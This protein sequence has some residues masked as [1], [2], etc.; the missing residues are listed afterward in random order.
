LSYSTTVIKAGNV[1]I[2]FDARKELAAAPFKQQV[3]PGT[4]ERPGGLS[5]QIIITHI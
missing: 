1:L 3:N 2:C 5:D 4:A